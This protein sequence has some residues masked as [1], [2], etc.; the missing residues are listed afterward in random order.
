MMRST[1][2]MLAAAALAMAVILTPPAV[3]AEMQVRVASQFGLAY[4]PLIIMQHD[5]SWEALA[6][7]E[8]VDL[9]VGWNNLGGGGALN[10]AVLSDSAD[11]AAGGVAPMLKVWDKTRKKYDVRAVAA[12]NSNSFY[13]VTNKPQIH[14]LRDFTE[15]DKIAVPTIKVSLQAIMLQMAAE[16]EFGLGQHEKLDTLTVSMKHPDALISLLSQHSSISAHVSSSPF[17]EQELAWPGIHKLVDYFAVMGGP[18][19]FSVVWAKESFVSRKPVAYATFLRALD[20]AMQSIK[21]DPAAAARKYLAVTGD[22]A[23]EAATTALIVQPDNIYTMAPQ[24]TAKLADF[25]LRT[26]SLTTR[27]ASWKDYFFA[28]VYALDGS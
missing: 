10:D 16:R 18:A 6:K 11:L 22:K 3:A 13:I 9:T 15:A 19:T 14:T 4:L 20:A 26:G 8:G 24:A 28:G 21:A 1:A 12:L 2:A 7:A 27:P 23:S 17:Q 5:R 25:M